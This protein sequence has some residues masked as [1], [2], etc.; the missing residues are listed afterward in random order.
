MV[1]TLSMATR[2][3]VRRSVSLPAQVA[4]QV[5]GIARRRRLSENRVLVELIEEG[6]E[7]QK[8]KE[9]AFFQLAER[10]RAAKDPEE[11]TRLGNDMGRFVFGD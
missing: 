6:I 8:R 9:K 7:A 10:F 5:D 11:I 2:K 4:K 3:S 1:Y